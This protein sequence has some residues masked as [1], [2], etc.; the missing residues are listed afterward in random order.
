DDQY[1]KQV[2]IKVVRRG[3]DTADLLARF[4]TERQILANLEH[5]YIAR[6]LD[7]GSTADGRPFLVMEYVEGLALERYCR[8][9]N[10]SIEERCRL[11]LKVCE[12][13]A[14]AHR[15]LVVHRDLKPANILITAEG[16]PKLLDF[17]VAKIL[18]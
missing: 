8:E 3:M 1:N 11:F 5:P 7:G 10:L 4:R 13:L 2:A 15:S 9:R 16:S 12:A 14:H 17:G 6:L 18:A